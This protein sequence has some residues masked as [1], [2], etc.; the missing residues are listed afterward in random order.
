MHKG[1]YVCMRIYFVFYFL[2]R[3]LSPCFKL[4]LSLPLQF[5]HAFSSFPSILKQ[6]GKQ[7]EIYLQ[8]SPDCE[9]QYDSKEDRMKNND[10]QRRDKH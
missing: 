6:V 4:S 5:F 10:E 2:F 1:M 9:V 8:L 3:Q 7:Q